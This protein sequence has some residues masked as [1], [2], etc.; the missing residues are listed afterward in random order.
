MKRFQFP[1]DRVLR[2]RQLQ[3]ETEEARLQAQLARLHQIE[4]RITQLDNEGLRTEQNVRQSIAPRSEVNAS[5]ML[6]YPNYRSVLA[7][8]RQAFEEERRRRQADV[9][10]Q[11]KVVLE[12]FRAQEIL[13]RARKQALDR[14]RADYNKEQDNAAGE[15]FLTKWKRPVR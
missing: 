9:E 1:L 2:F 15:L 11:R 14:W 3:A 13:E 7:R 4:E 12:A 10:R 8:G 6:T 5:A